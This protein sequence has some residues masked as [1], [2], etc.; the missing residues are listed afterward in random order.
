METIPLVL[1]PL[2]SGRDTDGESLR[3]S[4]V[5]RPR[6]ASRVR[7]DSGRHRLPQASRPSSSASNRAGCG[8]RFR[9]GG[10]LSGCLGNVQRRCH[11]SRRQ[12]RLNTTAEAG[13][14]RCPWLAAR[15]PGCDPCRAAPGDQTAPGSSGDWFSG[16]RRRQRARCARRRHAGGRRAPLRGAVPAPTGRTGQRSAFPCLCVACAQSGL[17]RSPRGAGRCRPEVGVPV[18]AR[19]SAWWHGRRSAAPVGT[20]GPQGRARAYRHLRKPRGRPGNADLWSA[21]AVRRT[22]QRR[23]AT[24]ENRGDGQGTPTSGRHARSAGPRNG[25]PPPAKTAG[26]ARERRPLGGSRAGARNQRRSVGPYRREWRTATCENRGD[27]AG[28]ADAPRSSSDRRWAFPCRHVAG[29]RNGTAPMARVRGAVPT[30]R[31]A[32]PVRRLLNRDCAA[33]PAARGGADRRSAFPC[34]CVACAQ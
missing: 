12:A 9:Y 2:P 26:T 23:T 29:A 7:R 33:R 15:R 18:P 17:R 10:D 6:R 22:A 8:C 27:G 3:G 30:V 20:R 24:R 5:Q 31:S 1:R 32:P 4:G 28:N 21:R 14:R 25:V 11:S 19:R 16:G 34:L 13:P